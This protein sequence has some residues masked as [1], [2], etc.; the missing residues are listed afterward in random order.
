M[1]ENEVNLPRII[2]FAWFQ[3]FDNA[4]YVVRKCRESWVARNPGWRVM[5]IDAANLQE[6]T[7]V[8]YSRGNIANLSMQHRAGLL[9]LDLLSR[10]G[11]VWADATCFCV[12]SLDDWLSPHM[13]SGFFAFH[14]PGPD[15]VISSWFLAAE[16][17]NVLVARLF[18]QMLAYWRDHPLRTDERQLIAKALTR[19]LKTSPVT[20]G[21]WFSRVV[22]DWL[23]VGPYFAISYGL[24]KLIREDPACA[25]AWEITPRVSADGPHRLYNAGL[26]SPASPE[27]RA[28]IDS[29]EIPVYKTTW[30]TGG[31]TIPSNS[32]LE[33]LLEMA[34]T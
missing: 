15:R 27:L 2:W 22:R 21:W 30:R 10:H 17:D 4:P 31:K 32:T 13:R 29:R 16:P 20:R 23:A 28:E 11:G 34:R 24:E 25:R 9:R 8:D 7:S 14:R 19:L 3:G 1:A 18:S 5:S 6:F 12:Q 33:Y 26:L